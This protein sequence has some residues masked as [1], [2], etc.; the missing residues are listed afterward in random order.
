MIP[1]GE[2]DFEEIRHANFR[3]CN[4]EMLE[5]ISTRAD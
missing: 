5:G 2:T 1:P 3:L 4:I